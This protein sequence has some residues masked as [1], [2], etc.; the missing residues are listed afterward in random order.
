M[1]A[2]STGAADTPEVTPK[3]RPAAVKAAIEIFRV[4]VPPFNIPLSSKSEKP[5]FPRVLIDEFNF[6][7]LYLSIL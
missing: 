5:V 4:T 7:D 6:D 2:P 1:T 3:P